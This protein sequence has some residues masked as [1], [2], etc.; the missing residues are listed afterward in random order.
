MSIRTKLFA[1]IITAATAVL[2]GMAWLSNTSSRATIVHEIEQRADVMLRSSRLTIDDSIARLEGIARTSAA[3]LERFSPQTEEDLKAFLQEIVGID[4][5]IYGSAI[6]FEPDAFPGRKG[7]VAPYIH[8]SAQGPAF[9]DLATPAYN[10]PAQDW[11]LIPRETRKPR[12]SEPYVDVGGGDVAMV[13][14]AIPF[15]RNGLVQGIATID[16]ALRDLTRNIGELQIADSGY[17]FLVNSKG[18]FLTMPRKGEWNL[19]RT[20]LDVAREFQGDELG[21]I[22]KQMMAGQTGFVSAIDPVNRMRAWFAFAPIT[23]TGWSLCLVFPEDEMLEESRS[24]HA[25]MVAIAAGGIALLLALIALIAAR[26]TRPI[27]VLAREA[28]RIASGDFTSRLAPRRGSDETA[29][30][31]RA[32]AE[33]EASLLAM[34]EKLQKEKDVFQAGFSEMSDG[35]VICDADGAPLQHNRAADHLLG[36]PSPGT[37]LSHL[38]AHF[39]STPSLDRLMD[40]SQGPRTFELARKAS[41]AMGA[42]QLTM[43]VTPIRNREGQLANLVLTVRDVTALRAEELSKKNFLATISHKLRTPVAAIQAGVSM[44][45]DGLLGALSDN[46]QRHIAMMANQVGKLQTLIE[47]LIGFVTIEEHGLSP[48]REDIDLPAL[49]GQLSEKARGQFPEKHPEISIAIAAQAATI[50]FHRDYLRLMLG[51]LIHNGL[52]FNCS[53]P[54]TV[55]V[56]CAREGG[57]FVFT[58]ADN[59]IGIPPEH[60]ERIFEKFYQVEKYFTGNVEGVGLGLAYVRKIVDAFGGSIEVA[61][62]PGVGSTFTVRLPHLTA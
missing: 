43:A 16:I 58:I 22:G 30:L 25:R 34:L 17:A 48:S 3:A 41:D 62:T 31:T 8:R 52:K 20:I 14:Y 37:L 49:L 24:L 59:G 60:R 13:T 38:L 19:T 4:P 56:A 53:D 40:F 44:T 42:L 33:M 51:E 36:L 12:W 55:S 50:S 15:F 10:Y 45:R 29:V 35:I 32:L 6:A 54:A 11:Y 9:V 5:L 23:S 57:A 2:V 61:S 46:Q 26:I 39:D 21:R 28:R 27:V 7:L 18:V 47:E 1:S